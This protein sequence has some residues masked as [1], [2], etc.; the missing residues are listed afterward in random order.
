MDNI[1]LASAEHVVVPP[2]EQQPSRQ[3]DEMSL[4]AEA[5]FLF[6][7]CLSLLAIIQFGHT[8]LVDNDGFF[9]IKMGLLIREQGLTPTFPWLPLSILNADDYYD[10][11]MLYHIFLALFTGDGQAST[12]IL[13]AKIASVLVPAWACM[14][15]WWLLHGQG[16][17]WAMLWT[18]GLFTLSEAFLY[19][20]SMP[21]VQAASL[22]VLVIGLHWLLHRR[23]ILLLPLGFIYVWLY[24]AFPLLIVLAGSYVVATLLTERR[25]PWQALALPVAGIMLGLVINPYFPR[26]ISFILNHLAPK[27]GELDVAVGSE[28]YPYTTWTLVKNSGGALAVW[29]LGVLG[30]GWHDRRIDRVTLTAFILSVIFGLL[31]FKS[32]RFIEY[33]PAFALI[34]AALSC[35]PLLNDWTATRQRWQWLMPVALGIG[36]LVPLV[37]TVTQARAAVAQSKPAEMY[38]A[39]AHWLQDQSPPG[40]LV[41]Q[42]DWDDF[43]RLFFYNTSNIYT[44]GLD[45]TYMQIYDDELYK[46]WVRITRGEVERPGEV[47]RTRFGAAYVLSDLQHTRFLERAA[48]DPDLKEVYRDADAVIFAVIN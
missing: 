26:N 9:H 13:G 12:M 30:M 47:M 4:I 37:L 3:T 33:F 7:I 17:R 1:P 25:L 23:Y 18:I 31:L 36:M 20:M 35:A 15:I 19:R 38:A 28:W 29:L 8:G 27:I 43:P 42:T 48:D 21:R 34:F 40:S 39:A 16:V 46:E 6:A 41:F 32:R 10:H 5:A 11:H 2:R 45:P 24:N 14:A 44:I 22:L